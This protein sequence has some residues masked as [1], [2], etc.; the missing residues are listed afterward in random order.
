[1]R[2]WRLRAEMSLEACKKLA[3]ERRKEER[4]F[5]MVDGEMVRVHLTRR[6]PGPLKNWG[7]LVH[8]YGE[9]SGE[10]FDRRESA[11]SYF[12]EFVR[13]YALKFKAVLHPR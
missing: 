9:I 3:E 4:A 12:D 7:V 10:Y 11:D 1:M 2:F 6:P 13:K 5:G 8:A